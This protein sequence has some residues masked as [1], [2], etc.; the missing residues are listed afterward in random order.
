MAC[1]DETQRPNPVSQATGRGPLR[2]WPWMGD[3]LGSRAFISTHDLEGNTQ[4]PGRLPTLPRWPHIP[5]TRCRS[6]PRSS[7]PRRTSCG[8]RTTSRSRTLKAGVGFYVCSPS[9]FPAAIRNSQGHSHSHSPRPGLTQRAASP[10]TP[11]ATKGGW[12]THGHSR[13]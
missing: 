3:L 13:T 11:V 1:C 12:V 2:L 7:W 6:G 5:C 9:V 4:G 8:G 10:A